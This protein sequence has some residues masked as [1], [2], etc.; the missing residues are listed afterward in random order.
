MQYIFKIIIITI[1]TMTRIMTR[2]INITITKISI[3]TITIT[4]KQ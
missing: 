4:R 1:I 2:I 3:M